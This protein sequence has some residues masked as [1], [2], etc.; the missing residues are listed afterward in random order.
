MSLIYF[1]VFI[2]FLSNKNVFAFEPNRTER[3]ETNCIES[4]KKE[5]ARHG[6]KI[7]KDKIKKA[8][9]ASDNE[10]FFFEAS[11]EFKNLSTLFGF[12]DSLY[13]KSI[14]NPYETEM[15]ESEMAKAKS[16]LYSGSFSFYKLRSAPE[17]AHGCAAHYLILKD[18][19]KAASKN[20]KIKIN[21]FYF[22]RHNRIAIKASS[23][24]MNSLLAYVNFFSENKRIEKFSNITIE[25]KY[26]KYY[27]G[28]LFILDFTAALR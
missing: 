6:I 22:L 28:A 16:G 5:A 9:C 27:N 13:E 2:I 21:K 14:L 17:S 20:F 19:V 11:I 3:C 1:F 12:F 4:I 23:H 10:L 24:Y 15:I 7:V 26:D 18:A 25:K 8:E